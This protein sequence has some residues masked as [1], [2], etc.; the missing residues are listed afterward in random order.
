MLPF[1]MNELNPTRS[2]HEEESL[3]AQS[4]IWGPFPKDSKITAVMFVI[5]D[6]PVT[7]KPLNND[8]ALEETTP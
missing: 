7:D 8:D 2:T 1:V 6:E 5:L 3:V 4:T